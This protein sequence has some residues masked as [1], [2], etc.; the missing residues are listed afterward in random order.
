MST[1]LL[2]HGIDQ[3]CS[4]HPETRKCNQC[5]A[6]RARMCNSVVAVNERTAM[7]ES[8]DRIERTVQIQADIERVWSLI[9]EPGWW[10]NDGAIVAHKIER[11][12]DTSIVHDPAHGAFVIKH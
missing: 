10:V 12:G 4:L 8:T 6:R 1:M 11:D 3:G 9:S 5:V 7:S 2:A